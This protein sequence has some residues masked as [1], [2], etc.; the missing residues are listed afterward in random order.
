MATASRRVA[1]GD[2]TDSAVFWSHAAR[3]HEAATAIGHAPPVTN[4]K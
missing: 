1:T 4:P 2:M 3:S